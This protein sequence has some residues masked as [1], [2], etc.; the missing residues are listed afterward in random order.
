MRRFALSA[1]AAM[2]MLLCLATIALWIRSYWYR[3][4]TSFGP[5]GGNCHL[6]QS[7]LGRIHVLSNLDGGC[8]G[9]F[10]YSGPDR[11]SPQAIWNGGMSGYPAQLQWHAGFIWQRYSIWHY[12]TIGRYA[13]TFRSNHRLIVIPFWC[14]AIIFAIPPLSWRSL[15]M[16]PRRPTPGICPK[17]GYDMRATPHR[18][19]ECGYQAED[20]A[21]DDDH[22]DSAH[23]GPAAPA[24][25]ASSSSISGST[26]SGRSGGESSDTSASRLPISVN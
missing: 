9:G 18:C 15:R 11:L 4:I 12:D 17:C 7:L 21:R 3:D 8:T 5:A 16:R 24:A 26:S 22:R 14:P 6:V 20:A 23:D 13:G 2:S 1:L 10:S 25:I 19:P